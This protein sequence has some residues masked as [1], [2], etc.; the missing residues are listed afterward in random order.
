VNFT[1]RTTGIKDFEKYLSEQ[2]DRTKK[3]AQLAIN[4]T[5]RKTYARSKQDIMRQVNLSSSYLDGSGIGEPRLRIAQFASENDLSGSIQARTRPTSLSRFDVQQM[6]APAKKGG[7]KKAG[8]SVNV[9][10]IRR[11]IPKAF[12]VNLR[13]GN[14]DGGNV[15]VAIR[16]PPG[17]GVLGRR[18]K[19]VPFGGKK[20]G[21]ND[22]YLLYGPSV[23]QVFDDVAPKQIPWA[24]S[25]LQ[26]QFTRQYA[27]LTDAR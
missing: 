15:G 18:Y 8:V 4:D 21:N 26:R 12:L 24:Q 14:Q 16:V 17:Q 7:R 27:R 23:Q 13:A 11:K 5:V 19:G 3:A 2:P 20:A 22:V 9:S 10:G 6:Y 1:V 25:Y